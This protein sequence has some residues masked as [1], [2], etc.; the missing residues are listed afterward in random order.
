MS[1]WALKYKG[2]SS[3]LH[4]DDFL[5]RVETL[6]QS[7]DIEF[8]RLAMGM[9]FILEG[10]ALEWFWIYQRENPN[11]NWQTFRG[12]MSHQFSKVE[13]QFEIW[14]QIRSRKQRDSESFG[15]LYIAVAALAGRLCLHWK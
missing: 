1:K 3:G 12:A 5:F 4:V 13:N 14:D 11:A 9:P 7:L 6:A 2:T 10:E 15:Q 8:N